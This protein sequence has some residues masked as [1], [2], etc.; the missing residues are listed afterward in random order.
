LFHKVRHFADEKSPKGKS[1]Q[2]ERNKQ[3]EAEIEQM[4]EDMRRVTEDQEAANEEL[5]SANEELLS[6]SEELQTLNEELETS[7]EELQ[8]NN[9]ELLTVNDE[10]I[11]RQEQLTVARLYSEAVIQ[12][13]REPLVILNKE[14]RIKSANAAFFK[15]MKTTEY[16][17]E[18]KIIFD[19]KI[20]QW[21]IG[22]LKT[23]LFK[24][25]HEKVT[26]EDLEVKIQLPEQGERTML[27]NIRPILNENLGEPLL[28]LA[29]E[30]ITDIRAANTMLQYN[31]RELIESNKELT[32]FSY[33]ASHDLQE[34]LRKIHT[35]SK[36]ILKDPE[37]KMSV[38][39]TA[40][41][42]RIMVSVRRMQQ[43]TDDLLKYSHL[44]D[45]NNSEFES[46]DLNSVV[47]EAIED[48]SEVVAAVNARIDIANLPIVMGDP[49]LL[50]QL[51][52][53]LVG[54]ALKYK[55]PERDPIITIS[56]SVAD[57]NEIS[58]LNGDHATRYY[59]ITVADNGIGFLPEQSHR[60]FEPFQRLHGKDKYEGTGIGLAICSKI[61]FQHKGYISAEGKP[62]QGAL[63]NVYLPLL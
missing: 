1:V 14:F 33:I 54:N 61:A 51:F 55:L 50:R 15:Y 49:L 56:F 23:E 26:V 27:L 17:V 44:L 38:E 35:F 53:N 24:A 2:T 40:Y 3:L 11:D 42:D 43:L 5:Q 46:T 58:H 16:D 9:E 7:A 13:I 45:T 60:I 62:G 37:S 6:N 12:T 32:S 4:R 31:N 41:L 59:K 21:T 63:F 20:A 52:I 18:G 8:S 39:A 28:L 10:L 29:I 47:S 34:P 48:L 22:N 19:L 36:L 25:L 57:K 30:D